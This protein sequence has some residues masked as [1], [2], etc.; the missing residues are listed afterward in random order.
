MPLICVMVYLL[1]SFKIEWDT[2]NKQKKEDYPNVPVIENKENY[3][4]V[5]KQ[6]STFTDCIS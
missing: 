5:T 4:K 6:V 3:R 1:S 2:Y